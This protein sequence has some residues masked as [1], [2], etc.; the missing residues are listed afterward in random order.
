MSISDIQGR[1]NIENSLFRKVFEVESHIIKPSQ[2]N[3]GDVIIRYKSRD[4]IKANIATSGPVVW[5]TGSKAVHIVLAMGS[6]EVIDPD[7]SF[8][9]VYRRKFEIMKDE[10]FI[11]LRPKLNARQRVDIKTVMEKYAEI[12]K[13]EPIEF[14]GIKGA[15]GLLGVP[16]YRLPGF[17]K[18]LEKKFEK[19]TTS[20]EFTDWVFKGIGV[21]LTPKSKQSDT[22]MPADIVAS[23]I[24]EFKGL[25]F[26]SE[27]DLEKAFDRYFKDE[28]MI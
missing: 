24:L 6:G 25:M 20:G 19:K 3:A 16:F 10:M 23:H 26:H 2:L 22:V 9:K 4:Y 28:M 5:G 18:F 13:Q 14:S 11:V 21:Y 1:L 15:G 27:E 12:S 7:P 8:G 17:K